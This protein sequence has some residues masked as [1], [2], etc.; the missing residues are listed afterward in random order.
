MINAKAR[1]RLF[2][3]SVA[4]LMVAAS[5][6]QPAQAQDFTAKPVRIIVT[7]PG[8]SSDTLARVLTAE[9]KNV[10][11]H[12]VIVE[13]KSGAGGLIPTL[14]VKSAPPD[15][16]TLLLNTSAFIVSAE[17]RKAPPYDPIAD[18]APVAL[19]GKGPLLLVA[20]SSLPQNTLPE[21]LAEARR[22]PGTFTYGST[23]VG[24]ITH[25]SAELL[26]QEA[27]VQMRH[28]PFKG[29]AQVISD[30]A[31]GQIDLYLGSIS[32]SLQLVQ[33]GRLKALAVTSQK[34]SPFA[35]GVPAAVEAGLPNFSLELWWGLFA[36]AQTPKLVIEEINRQI[37]KAL[38]KP[39]V[40]EVF[41]KEGVEPSA[42]S[43]EQFDKF[44]RNEQARWTKAI[45]SS[46]FVKE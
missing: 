46:K 27:G 7:G 8:G 35:P 30:L 26:F 44:L 38:L 12:P 3:F 22:K 9:I 34:P 2:P 17:T 40:R 5:M 16:H 25:L 18:F 24:G 31:G 33:A 1:F 29:G 23:G 4:I 42:A 36:P 10:W 19:L 45:V 15:G 14:T 21:L 37:N 43:P 39:A 11:T 20:R 28:I 6:G 13:N 32:L 41:V